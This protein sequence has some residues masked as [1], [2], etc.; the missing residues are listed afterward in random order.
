MQPAPDSKGLEVG[1]AGKH[2][3]N[4]HVFKRLNKKGFWLI[5]TKKILHYQTQKPQV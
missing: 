5:A 1:R 2:L 4:Q 3:N